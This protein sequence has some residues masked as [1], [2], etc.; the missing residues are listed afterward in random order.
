MGMK[1]GTGESCVS[2]YVIVI[3]G[4]R[5]LFY[6]CSVIITTFRFLEERITKGIVRGCPALVLSAPADLRLS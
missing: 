5:K 4:R 1:T 2:L 6:V 3:R